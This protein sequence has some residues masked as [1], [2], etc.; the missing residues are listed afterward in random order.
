EN[1]AGFVDNSIGRPLS[2]DRGTRLLE[3]QNRA[4][5]GERVARMNSLHN[6]GRIDEVLA[7]PG[8]A[9]RIATYVD[10]ERRRVEERLPDNARHLQRTSLGTRTTRKGV[11]NLGT[12]ITP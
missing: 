11:F 2:V 6:R 10:P 8:V 3:N 4:R 9:E 7:I 5:G 1:I 12:E